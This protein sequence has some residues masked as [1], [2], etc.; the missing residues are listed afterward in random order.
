MSPSNCSGTDKIQGFEYIFITMKDI[1]SEVEWLVHCITVRELLFDISAM[2]KLCHRILEQKFE[3]L[4]AKNQHSWN[5]HNTIYY[6]IKFC[7]TQVMDLWRYSLPCFFLLETVQTSG[8][9]GCNRKGKQSF[10][11]WH[12][13]FLP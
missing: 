7:M 12:T 6:S 13:T 4:P 8:W 5:G 1:T 10:T 11:Y 9:K 2:S 3:H